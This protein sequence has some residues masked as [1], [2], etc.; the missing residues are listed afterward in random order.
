MKGRTPGRPPYCVGFRKPGKEPSG[1][2][3][4]PV[5]AGD[6]AT[7]DLA[8]EGLA[9]DLEADVGAGDLAVGDVDGLA[10]Y[11]GLAGEELI[12]LVEIERHLLGAVDLPLAANLGGHD[13]EIDVPAVHVLMHFRL[14]VAHV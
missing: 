11:L 2:G 8:R 12:L 9:V 3:R 6:A 13:P 1:L 7:G 5:V 10:A 4:L 14:P